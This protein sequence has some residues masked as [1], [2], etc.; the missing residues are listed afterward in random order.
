MKFIG[1][2]FADHLKDWSCTVCKKIYRVP[3]VKVW[4][5]SDYELASLVCLD[6]MTGHEVELEM[7]RLFG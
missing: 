7:R 6:C 5:D 3:I 4:G 2:K 1:N